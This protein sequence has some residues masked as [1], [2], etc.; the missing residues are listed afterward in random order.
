[1]N[2]KVLIKTFFKGYDIWNGL[3][4]YAIEEKIS[5]KA[6]KNNFMR[7]VFSEIT[8]FYS[9]YIMACLCL[10]LQQEGFTKNQISKRFAITEYKVRVYLRLAKNVPPNMYEPKASLSLFPKEKFYEDAC[11]AYSLRSY[12]TEVIAEKIGCSKSKVK[13]L[14]KIA[15]IRRDYI[16]N[17]NITI[18]ILREAIS[19][20]DPEKYLERIILAKD[21][22]SKASPPQEDAPLYKE[23]EVVISKIK[24]IERENTSLKEENQML[25]EQLSQIKG[26]VNALIKLAV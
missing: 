1:M 3:S 8:G 18:S 15:N 7:Y 11:K 26:T 6:A 20:E 17:E 19:K 14:L 9:D 2:E 16:F 24:D 12:P 13:Y 22:S 25:R 4:L 23:I 21:S 5:Y 10:L